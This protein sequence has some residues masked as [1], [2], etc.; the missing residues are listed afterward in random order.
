MP[1]PLSL[2]GLLAL[3][4]VGGC[5][6]GP[7]GPPPGPPPDIV[8]FLLDTVRG[9]SVTL[10]GSGPDVTPTLRALAA[11]GV[12]FTSAFTHTTW[13][14]PAVATLFTS[15]YPTQ[16]SVRSSSEEGD[17][18]DLISNA[19][20]ESLE[21]LA[22]RLRA[23]GYETVAVLNQVH[24]RPKFKFDQG[25]DEYHA[26]RGKSAAQLNEVLGRWI[27]ARS[28]EESRPFFLYV[29][30]LD[31]HWPYLERVHPLR[32][33]LGSVA[34]TSEPPRQGNQVEAWAAGG[35]SES[36]V[37]ALRARYLHGVAVTDR[38]MGQALEMLREA[39]LMDD[40]VVVATSDHGEGMNEHGKLQHGFEPY[41]ELHR[42]P[43]VVRLPERLRGE[44]REVSDLVGLVDVLPTLTELSG[45]PPAAGDM[46][47]SLLPLIRGEAG[48]RERPVFSESVGVRSLR[49]ADRKLIRHPDGREEYY[50]LAADPRETTSLPCDG[51]CA[52]LR[53]QLD[54]L[55]ELLERTARAETDEV[56]LDESDLER[57]RALGYLND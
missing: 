47:R 25:F 36:D 31:P 40:T 46:G 30:Y 29:H 39:G 16:H 32:K 51:A 44:V 15:R 52:D 54:E 50:D 10:D 13:T 8:V 6:R 17:D 2:P 7:L 55:S 35:L 33:E 26:F 57:L 24:L 28:P 53:R 14:K 4:L 27:A 56:E 48:G 5:A 12:A 20:P 9:D 42:V 43:L 21:T 11:E 19:L 3:L 23:A 18:G 37:L 41:E 49:T 45:L 38:Y 34:M 22:E 1:R